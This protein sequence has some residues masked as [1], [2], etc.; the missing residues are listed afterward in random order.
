MGDD[1][2]KIRT[3]GLLI[4]DDK[5]YEKVEKVLIGK[6]AAPVS[7]I[8]R[9]GLALDCRTAD[10][11]GSRLIAV[12]CGV[13]KTNAAA[14]TA[15]LIVMGAGVVVSGGLSGKIT[16]ADADIIIGTD[17]YE[18][19]FDL[20]VL[21]YKAGEK[22]FGEYRFIADKR[23]VSAA[24]KAFPEAIGGSVVTGDR[25]ICTDESRRFVTE[26]FS[27]LACDMESAAEAA[28]CNK[29]GIPFL[30]VR[31]ISDNA[32]ESATAAYRNENNGESGGFFVRF[33]EFAVSL[34]EYDE[35]WSDK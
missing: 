5:E 32:D 29:A 11:T 14:A 19:D 35:I 2:E 22:P 25:F 23:L 20:T 30:S 34:G 24:E 1:M 10:N 18:H 33:T 6:G 31:C 26:C 16:D 8:G 12:Y 21:G 27:A 13:G 9:A 3:V 4:A 15:A 17:Y 7:V 28:V